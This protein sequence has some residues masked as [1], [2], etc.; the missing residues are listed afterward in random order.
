MAAD[1]PEFKAVL[2]HQNVVVITVSYGPKH[3]L[4]SADEL[5]TA[6]TELFVQKSKTVDVKC[7][8]IIRLICDIADSHL[9]RAIFELYKV[10]NKRD[11]ILVCVGYP[12]EFLDSLTA[13]GV[14]QLPKFFLR[15][16]KAEA[17]KEIPPPETQ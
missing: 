10:V 13:V 11:G 16:T 9:V 15:A 1:E 8:C 5:K 2:E 17:F 6:V 14:H 3:H 4:R 7:S 12:E